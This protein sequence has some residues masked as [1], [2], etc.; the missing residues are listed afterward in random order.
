MPR[1]VSAD[2][3]LTGRWMRFAIIVPGPRGESGVNDLSFLATSPPAVAPATR[4]HRDALRA[5]GGIG[6]SLLFQQGGRRPFE[7]LLLDVFVI[8]EGGK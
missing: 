4:E 7:V 6:L 3:L 1:A 8:L 5:L 2:A